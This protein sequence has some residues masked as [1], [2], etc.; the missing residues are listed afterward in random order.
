MARFLRRRWGVDDVDRGSLIA[1]RIAFYGGLGICV[2]DA[3][4]ARLDLALSLVGLAVILVGGLLRYL[5]GAWL[6]DLWSERLRVAPHHRLVRRG[7]YRRIRNPS[8]LGLS[9][10]SLG[11]AITFQSLSG[12]VVF[13]VGV[14][15]ALAY[16]IHLE[17]QLLERNF[18]EEYRE[19][20][21][22]TKRLIPY[23]L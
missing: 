17:E 12:M 7:L 19:Y 20:T 6:G 1:L 23:V 10:V 15:P 3:V 4:G 22:R 18:G 5:A 16:R 13:L 21:R 9:L 2:L 14:A 11:A 8:Y